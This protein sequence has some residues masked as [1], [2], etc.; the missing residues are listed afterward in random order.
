LGGR[1]EGEREDGEREGGVEVH[2]GGLWGRR[3][4]GPLACMEL[5]GML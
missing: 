1:V 5:V 2:G 4:L 3:R